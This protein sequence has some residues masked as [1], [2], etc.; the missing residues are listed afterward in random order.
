MTKRLLALKCVVVSVLLTVATPAFA[1]ALI[2]GTDVDQI[3]DIARRYGSA[4]VGTDKDGDPKISGRIEGGLGYSILFYGCENGQNCTSIQFHA[5]FELSNGPSVQKL[6]DWNR[7]KRYFKAYLGKDKSPHVEMDVTL[8]HGVP[9][10][11]VAESVRLWTTYLK[12]FSK[13]I[14][15]SK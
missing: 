14:G 8:K 11:T 7:D 9:A 4:T 12:D 2:F 13:Y 6:N 5:G 10:D 3:A 1:Q 15:Y